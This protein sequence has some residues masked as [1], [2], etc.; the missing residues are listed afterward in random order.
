MVFRNQD[1]SA[2]CAHYYWGFTAW[3]SSQRTELE[4]TQMQT[5]IYIYT[6]IY[7]SMSSIYHLSTCLFIIYVCMYLSHIN[8]IILISP[9]AEHHHRVHLSLA[10]LCICKSHKE[11]PGSSYP[12][13]LL[14]CSIIDYTESNFSIANTYHCKNQTH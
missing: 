6:S 8:E 13:C 7:L 1:L 3:S 12:V 10:P 9:I 14:I 11:T 4:N 5:H 2:R